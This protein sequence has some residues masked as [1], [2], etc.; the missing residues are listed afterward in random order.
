MLKIM[1]EKAPTLC[2]VTGHGEHPFNGQEADGM[3]A[4]KDAL[5]VQAYIVKD[6]SLLE[7]ANALKDCTALVLPG[8]NKAIFPQE[9]KILKD[10]LANGGR[11]VLAYNLDPKAGQFPAG[12]E[13]LLKDWYIKPVLGLVIDPVSRMLGMDTSMPVIATHSKDSAITKD[14]QGNAFFPFATPLEIIPGAPGSLTLTWLGQTTPKS[15]LVSDMKALASGRVTVDPNKSKMGPFNAA[16][17]AEGKLKDSKAEKKTRV[18]AFGTSQFATNNFAKYGINLDYLVNAISWVLDDESVISVRKKDD[19]ASRLELSSRMAGTIAIF[20]MVIIPL[21]VAA[22]GI[23]FWLI[24][25]R[26]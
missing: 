21:L 5:E 17:A 3:K 22:G 7:G 8:V 13:E 9:L 6:I 2:V 19:E 16:I 10:Y 11:M 15:I 14:F 4:V 26:M 1:K 23:V 18:V 24:R 25:R 20:T 12:I